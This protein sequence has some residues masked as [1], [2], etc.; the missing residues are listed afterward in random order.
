MFCR[1]VEK[2]YFVVSFFMWIIIKY[3]WCDI[4]NVKKLKYFLFNFFEKNEKKREKNYKWF[5]KQAFHFFSAIDEVVQ[6]RS[7]ELNLRVASS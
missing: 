2:N 6:K 3:D 5:V 1:K 7:K 4:K